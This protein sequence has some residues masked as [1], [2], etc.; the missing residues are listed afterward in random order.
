METVNNLIIICSVLVLNQLSPLKSQG[1]N[2]AH[3]NTH[4]TSLVHYSAL[5]ITW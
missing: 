4:T 2:D 1:I 5:D 3:T